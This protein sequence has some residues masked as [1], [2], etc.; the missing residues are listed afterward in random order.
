MGCQMILCNKMNNK[1]KGKKWEEIYGKENAIIR[2]QKWKEKRKIKNLNQITESIKNVFKYEG[3]INKNQFFQN[4]FVKKELGYHQKIRE[5]LIKNNKTLDGIAKKEKLYFNRKNINLNLDDIIKTTKNIFNNKKNINKKEFLN[6]ISKEKNCHLETVRRRLREKNLDLNKLVELLGFS[7]KPSKWGLGTNEI[8][9]LNMIEKQKGIILKKQ[10]NVGK[11]KLD[12]Y[13]SINNIA[14]EV[15]EYNHKYQKIQ[16][17]IR[18]NK[19]KEKLGC[20]FVRIKEQE[21]LNKIN[22]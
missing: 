4:K 21:W 7:F 13:D 12:G 2:R 6:K 18:E 9:I 14:Y 15:D 17:T 10:F 22:Q 1:L 5:F 11:Y 16:D 3:N 20:N 19:I 8:I